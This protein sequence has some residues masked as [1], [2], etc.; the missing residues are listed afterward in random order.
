MKTMLQLS[1]GIEITMI[2]IGL[3]AGSIA[4]LLCL[5]YT[6]VLLGV[7]SRKNVDDSPSILPTTTDNG[8]PDKRHAY[9]QARKNA[10]LL[11]AISSIQN[12]VPLPPPTSLVPPPISRSS[13]KV[14]S[15][16]VRKKRKYDEVGV[17]ADEEGSWKDDLT[18]T[19]SHPSRKC[20]VKATTYRRKE[21]QVE[22]DPFDCYDKQYEVALVRREI[23]S[24]ADTTARWKMSSSISKPKVVEDLRSPSRK[25]NLKEV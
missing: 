16:T 11:A 3:A 21:E 20:T 23:E 1:K 4:T 15:Y 6:F 13:S 12:E 19:L 18:I 24:A 2:I 10:E 14:P 17:T 5:V 22:T 25:P 8:L 7:A 9:S